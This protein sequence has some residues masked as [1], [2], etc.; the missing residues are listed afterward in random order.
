MATIH[1]LR[2]APRADHVPHMGNAEIIIFPGVRY[3]RWDDAPPAP[4]PVK[5][6]KG[7]KP[8]RAKRAAQ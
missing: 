5:A 1:H 7:R 2:P 3:E 8:K 6:G 4:K